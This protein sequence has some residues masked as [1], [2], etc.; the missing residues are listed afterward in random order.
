MSS[1]FDD[2]PLRA[3]KRALT[4]KALCEALVTRLESRPLEDIGVGELCAEAGISQGTFFNY[5]PT[6]G[7]LLTHFIRLWSL[8]EAV[9][10]REAEASHDSALG[11]IE[12]IFA[13]TAQNVSPRPKLMLEVI[14]HN[15][16]MA[17][18]GELP[19]IE[20]AERLLLLPDEA[21]VM[22]LPDTG[23]GGLLP[24]LIAK[25]VAAGELPPSTDVG[26]VTLAV[27]SV[28]FGISLTVGRSAPEALGPVWQ[29]QL[30]LVWA[31]ARSV[32]HEPSQP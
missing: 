5:F 2:L 15:A 27:V 25:A 28:F 21:D 9:V 17:A 13:S 29:Q 12:A 3:R 7:D 23:L 10:A 19:P 8:K 20:E 1:R 24:P 14:A 4:R 22:G 26:M 30:R 31:G 18:T 16:R 11:A 32:G 6:K